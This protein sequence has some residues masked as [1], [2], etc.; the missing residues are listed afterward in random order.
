MKGELWRCPAC[1]EGFTTKNQW[2]ACGTFDI[3][4]LFARSDPI[5][6]RLY[7]AFLAAVRECG[8]VTVIP[9]K[10]RIA[11][12]V[13]MRFA[14]LIPQ[15]SA[16]RGHLVLAERRASPLFEKIETYSPRDHLHVFRLRSEDALD[17]HFR[18]LI[19]EAYAVGRQDH[20]RRAGA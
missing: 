14:A 16:L 10:S 11:L 12:Q 3:D 6:R 13:R 4:A 7:E 5:V 1:R 2:H 17:S 18:G 8:P 20:L 19:R 15:K 9:Q